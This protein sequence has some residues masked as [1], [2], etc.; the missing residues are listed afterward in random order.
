MPASLLLAL[1]GC[2]GGGG[3]AAPPPSG[4]PPTPAVPAPP[5]PP[6]APAPTN[7]APEIA[8]HI[9][10]RQ[11][12]QF[13]AIDFEVT[14]G[15]RVFVDP[16]GDPLTYQV[17][18]A[19]YSDPARPA[20]GMSVI[21]TRVV[22]TRQ[23]TQQLIVTVTARDTAGATAA[24]QFSILVAPNHPPQSTTER[25]DRLVG[26]GQGFSFDATAG[27]TFTDPDGDPITYTVAQRGQA[28]VTVQGTQV[29]GQLDAVGAVEITLHAAD[30]YGARGEAVFVIAAPDAA[31][32]TP[33]LPSTPFVYK[34]ESL[35][36]PDDFK[37]SSEIRLPLH[38]TQPTVNRTTDA[39]AALGR[40][41]FHDKR[42]SITNTAAC[43]TCH[44]REHGFAS[45]ERFNTGVLGVPLK[46]NSMA[47]ANARY[48]IH[49]SW[50]ADVRA[51]SIQEVARQALTNPEELGQTLPA[52]EQK[53]RAT[54]FY[55]PLFEAAFGTP[56]ITSERVLRALEQYVLALI[57]Y[58]T[59]YD[60]ACDTV[61]GVFKDC[62]QGLTA[63]EMRGLQ[64]FTRPG[65]DEISCTN[66]HDLP[67][68]ANVWLANNGI[69]VQFTDAG[70]GLGV[71]RPATLRNIALTAPYMHDGRFATLREVIDHYDHGIQ[72][73]P[74]LDTRLR[75]HDGT[76]KR[77]DLPEED[78]AALEAFL[79]TL[80]DD[81]MLSDPKFADPF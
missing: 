25:Q 46:R 31:S 7:R 55:G 51:F 20:P 74:F 38:D 33:T 18:V 56:E 35:P 52:L 45:A 8:Q 10:N 72:D 67:S 34:D 42:I 30:P 5:A 61:G 4:N 17:E 49:S 36:L 47:L 63:Q 9:P 75:K 62:A 28:A 37:L 41:L 79:H 57:S 23:D 65:G 71:F 73:S 66:C 14:D 11:A 69:D 3:S 22:G 19:A 24:T 50:F 2:G 59:K 81:A 58:R 15:G 6:P 12:I 77:M 53:L 48:N 26:L 1:I 68:A 32:A 64:L 27:R 16:D 43:V 39:G 13:H 70:S 29:S 78:K 76:A 44:A 60:Q 54:P 21:G 80:T 40:V